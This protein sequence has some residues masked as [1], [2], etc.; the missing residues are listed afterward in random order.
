VDGIN[1]MGKVRDQGSCG[2]CYTV[3]F[4]TLIENRLRYLSGSAPPDLSV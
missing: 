3:A 2:S 1:F 4:V